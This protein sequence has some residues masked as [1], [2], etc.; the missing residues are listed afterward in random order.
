MGVTFVELRGGSAGSFGWA[1][2]FAGAAAAPTEVVDPALGA[3]CSSIELDEASLQDALS[4]LAV[5]VGK[6]KV[7]VQFAPG[8]DESDVEIAAGSVSACDFPVLDER[9]AAEGDIAVPGV[10]DAAFAI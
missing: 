2:D 8:T 9:S 3:R 5:G 4:V 1:E 6:T 7:A 10:A